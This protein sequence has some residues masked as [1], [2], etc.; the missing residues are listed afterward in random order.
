MPDVLAKSRPAS[1]F[2]RKRT[3]VDAGSLAELDEGQPDVGVP[4]EM[5]RRDFVEHRIAREVVA[6]F[7]E[8]PDEAGHRV[9]GTHRI[10][11]G[12][13]AAPV[14]AVHDKAGPVVVEEQRL[15]PQERE[16]RKG[17]WL[18]RDDGGRCGQLLLV[19]DANRMRGSRQ[20]PAMP[21]SRATSASPMDAR[22]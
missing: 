2:E 3:E 9:R 16:I 21:N 4:M 22:R 14:H 19:G 17:R 6:S 8:F 13:P 10:A 20:E 12:D 7:E 5:L 11:Q 15:V 18:R 1:S